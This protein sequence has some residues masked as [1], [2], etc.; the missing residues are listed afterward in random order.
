METYAIN[1]QIYFDNKYGYYKNILTINTIPKGPLS[2]LVRKINIPKLS[3]F[4]VNSITSNTCYN[5]IYNE[6]NEIMD[7]DSYH[8]LYIYLLNNG[9]MIN[10]DL[11]NMINKST[12]K[13]TKNLL[14]FISYKID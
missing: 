2:S 13:S 12:F 6:K 10:S 8:E 9:Y 7:A 1:T 3:P 11:T 5:V 14:C 4:D